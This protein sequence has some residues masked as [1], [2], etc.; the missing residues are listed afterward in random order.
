MHQR[1]L[2]TDLSGVSQ[3]TVSRCLQQFTK[4]L[5]KKSHLFIRFPSSQ[6]ELQ[7]TSNDFKSIAGNANIKKYDLLIFNIMVIEHI[8]FFAGIGNIVG[9]IDCTHVRLLG[10]PD[11]D[12]AQYINRKSYFSVNIQVQYSTIASI[13]KSLS[14]CSTQISIEVGTYANIS[15]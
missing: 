12:A 14:K 1:T 6:R 10:P 9:A 15:V 5:N 11:E 3:S 13:C 2:Q 8:H 7:E 4:A